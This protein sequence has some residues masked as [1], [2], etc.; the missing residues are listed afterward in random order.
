MSVSATG[1]KSTDKHQIIQECESYNQ[2][3]LTIE[4]K[5]MCCPNWTRR[6][7]ALKTNLVAVVVVVGFFISAIG[8]DYRVR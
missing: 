3:T 5:K 7:Y 6:L 1:L 2:L 8:V 4:R